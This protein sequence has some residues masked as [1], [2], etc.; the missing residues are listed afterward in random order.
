MFICRYIKKAGISQ[1]PAFFFNIM[2][3]FL[4]GFKLSKVN[5]IP[6]T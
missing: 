5:D 4:P 6:T 3:V 1:Q 2:N